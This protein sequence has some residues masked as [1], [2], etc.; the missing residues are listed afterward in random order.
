MT[1]TPTAEEA[2]GEIARADRDYGLR[3][4]Q[5][6]GGPSDARVCRPSPARC[7]SCPRAAVALGRLSGP[8]VADHAGRDA[9]G[10]EEHA[11]ERARQGVGG[12][13]AVHWPPHP[14]GERTRPDRGG[15]LGPARSR[16]S[17]RI[18]G[19]QRV[20]GPQQRRPL[21]RMASADRGRLRARTQRRPASFSWSTPSPAWPASRRTG[22]RHGGGQHEAASARACSRV[23]PGRSLHPPRSF[24]R[25]TARLQGVPLG[26]RRVALSQGGEEAAHAHSPSRA[27]AG[28]PLHAARGQGHTHP[29]SG[30]VVL[31]SA[32]ASLPQSANSESAIE[33]LLWQMI[34]TAGPEGSATRTAP[35][36]PRP[37]ARCCQAA[38]ADL[39]RPGQGRP[40]RPRPR[41]DPYRWYALPRDEVIR[42]GAVRP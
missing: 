42:C 30:W 3:R 23:R 2:A 8:R 15:R 28:L 6:R 27:R 25:R 38:I 20:R 5:P 37:L 26:C 29:G 7:I 18:P 33:G 10:R 17:V 4:G 13:A 19:A 24:Q 31:R 34:I 14:P 22:K 1:T 41:G 11:S 40:P 35:R 32:G 16:R 39:A 21:T 36:L 9:Q 12:W